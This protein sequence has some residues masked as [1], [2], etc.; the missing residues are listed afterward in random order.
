MSLDI[1]IWITLFGLIAIGVPLFASLGISAF[2]VLVA[3][4]IP[5]NIIPLDLYKVS[6]MFPL[7]AIPGFILAG[8]IME[9]GGISQQIVEVFKMLIGKKRGGLGIVTILGC[10]FFAAMIGSG[11]ATVAA[12]GSIMIPSMVKS[13]YSKEYG[14]AVSSTGGTLGILIP[15][16]N[17][18]II[19]GVIANVSI[20]S[21]FAA[22]FAPGALVA[23]SLML[24][25][26]FI[27]RKHNYKGTDE[28]FTASEILKTT[29]KNTWSL[30]TPIIILGGIYAGIFTPVE[31]SVVAVLYALFVS[32]FITRK[33]S[34]KNFWESVK[35]TN[36]A[37][38]TVLIVV[39][40]SIL[41]GRFLTMYQVPQRLASAILGV[42]EDPFIVLVLICLALFVIGMFMETLA[43]IVI[44]VPVLLPLV[45]ELGIDPI[46]F[47]IIIVMTNEVALL[48]PPLGVNLFVAKSITGLS[49]ERIAKSVIP[50]IVVLIICVFIVARF[51]EIAL[52][53]PRL[54][55]P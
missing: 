2:I 23:T 8:S 37:S 30:L 26:Y 7:I 42:S 22:G 29:F 41:F 15:P 45:L 53:L 10:V 4:D 34:F 17:P 13:G 19:Y 39:A 40:V 36:V 35:F 48:T 27:A 20:A 6:E 33:F 16:S 31:A 28:T 11:P 54:F 32:I 50:Y 14:A 44:I 52:F 1:L 5:L 9:K 18:M 55:Y 49:V 47:G 25:A 12:M 43:T 24:T 51:E 3:T 46:H 21:L 38:G